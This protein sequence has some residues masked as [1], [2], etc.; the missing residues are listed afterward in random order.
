MKQ[1]KFVGGEYV[2]LMIKE[3]FVRF[4]YSLF[5]K[6]REEAVEKFH[7]VFPGCVMISVQ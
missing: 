7:I 3:S 4:A 6:S 2:D 5:A 1:F